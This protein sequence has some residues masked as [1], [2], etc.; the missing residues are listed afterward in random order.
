MFS[1]Y[2]D[3]FID[4]RTITLLSYVLMS[5]RKHGIRREPKP[6]AN[7]YRKGLQKITA[8]LFLVPGT[9]LEPVRPQW[10]RDFKSLVSTNS[11][12]WAAVCGCKATI[13]IGDR[14]ENGR[15]FILFVLSVIDD[16]CVSGV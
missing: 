4:I 5:D 3:L 6:A 2:A 8:S 15:F 16:Q 10:S 11:P 7:G 12:I 13:K 1:F 14:E 9:G